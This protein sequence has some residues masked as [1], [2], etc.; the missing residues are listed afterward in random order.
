MFYR[1]G[2][3]VEFCHI[4]EWMLSRLLDY[5]KSAAMESLGYQSCTVVAAD[6]DD[7]TVVAEQAS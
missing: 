1:Y 2:R 7:D 6:D 5:S 4:L 3:F